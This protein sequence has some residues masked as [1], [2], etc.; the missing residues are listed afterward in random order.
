M[1]KPVLLPTL[2]P[3]TCFTSG[4]VGIAE[5]PSDEAGMTF[6]PGLGADGLTRT[7]TLKA[8]SREEFGAFITKLP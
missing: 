6:L 3:V 5:F 2:Y 8:F 7:T 1:S 4:F